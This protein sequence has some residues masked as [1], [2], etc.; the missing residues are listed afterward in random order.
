[1]GIPKC[2]MGAGNIQQAHAADEFV[3]IDEVVNSAE[4]YTTAAQDFT[5]T[6]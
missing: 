1:M 5:R 4:I 2:L 6:C 3:E